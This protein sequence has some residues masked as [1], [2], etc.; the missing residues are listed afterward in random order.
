MSVARTDEL[1]VRG[2]DVADVPLNATVLLSLHEAEVEAMRGVLE[3][4]GEQEGGRQ[5]LAGGVSDE[6]DRVEEVHAG[7]VEQQVAVERLDHQ[8]RCGGHGEEH[9]H[10]R[11]DA[12]K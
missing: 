7:R 9:T 1:W 8:L 3:G 5:S 4:E 2:V 11:Q 6:V 12:H 10:E